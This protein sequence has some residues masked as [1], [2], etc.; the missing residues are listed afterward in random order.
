M[1][2]EDSVFGYRGNSIPNVRAGVCSSGTL[3]RHFSVP[4]QYRLSIL[5]N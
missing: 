3:L 1:L 2:A 4:E 5:R